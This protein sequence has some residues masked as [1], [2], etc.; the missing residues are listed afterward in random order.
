MYNLQGTEGEDQ[1]SLMS[2]GSKFLDKQ[3]I[4]IYIYIHIKYFYYIHLMRCSLI[5][6][7]QVKRWRLST[8]VAS[9]LAVILLISVIVIASSPATS[10]A[11]NNLSPTTAPS[12]RTTATTSNP[13]P[14]SSTQPPLP[15]SFVAYADLLKQVRDNTVDPCDDFYQHACGSWYACVC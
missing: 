7:S 11:N 4:C 9:G 2:G 1:S 12:L 3:V 6:H 14:P 10:A 15:A 13:Q 5:F 8:Y